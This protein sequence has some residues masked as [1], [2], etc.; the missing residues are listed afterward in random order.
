VAAWIAVSIL[1]YFFVA[2]FRKR[3]PFAFREFSLVLVNELDQER[4]ALIWH[5]DDVHY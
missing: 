1:W 5:I 4:R 2:Y 3:V